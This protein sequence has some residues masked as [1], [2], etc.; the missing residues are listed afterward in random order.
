M[1]FI[2]RPYK[3]SNISAA[4]KRIMPLLINYSAAHYD[5]HDAFVIELQA[6]FM[7]ALWPASV[8]Y[9]PLKYKGGRLLLI[10]SVSVARGNCK[11]VQTA[12]SH[13]SY[14][15]WSSHTGSLSDTSK[16]IS[17]RKWESFLRPCGPG[18]SVGIATGYGLDGPGIE[19]RWGARF[20]HTCP[21]RPWGPHS[22]LYNGYRLC[23]R[24]T[25]TL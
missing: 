23:T 14:T 2:F 22:L 18:S 1:S 10:S 13:Y 4:A 15:V 24:V 8:Q 11:R 3:S 9:F 5:N 19:S 16:D 25:F 7:F 21:D 20:F 12:V 17:V 6:Y